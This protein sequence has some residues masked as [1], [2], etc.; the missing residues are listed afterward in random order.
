M[1]FRILLENIE[2]KREQRQRRKVSTSDIIQSIR[3]RG[4]IT[5]VIVEESSEGKYNLIAGERRYSASLELG[6]RDIPARTLGSLSSTERS[7]IELE[8]NIKRSDLEWPDFCQAIHKIHFL[9]IATD[10]NWNQ[11]KTADSVGLEE[12]TV[13]IVLRVANELLL[14]NSRLLEAPNY[15]AAYN[16][17]ARKDSRRLDDAFNELVGEEE[18]APGALG[19]NSTEQ[20]STS[21]TIVS[22]TTE[23]VINTDFLEY[24]RTY[25]GPPYT[26]LHCDFPYGIGLDKSAQGNTYQWGGYADTE[27]LYWRLCQTLA[28]NLD[29]LMAPY[30]H[31]MFWL[32]S[33]FTVIHKTLQFFSEKAPSLDFNPKPL[34]WMKTDGKG[35]LADP[36]RGPRHIYETALFASRG[37]RLIAAP[38]AD[39]YGA[40]KGDTG[41]QSEKPEP[42]LRHFFRMFLDEGSSFFDPTC[43]SGSSICAAESLGAK[44]CV[45]LEIN[46]EWAADANARV[47]KSRTLRAINP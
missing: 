35:I 9:Y 7:I 37:D 47:K 12:G 2:V 5:P 16:I 20:P 1:D 3:R 44:S 24:A 36:K 14:G 13:S 15:R 43:G 31:L 11:S 22:T 25:R 21:S 45:G 26:F 34:I 28:E 10:S 30:S 18:P 33:D 6:L 19:V 32:S 29:R 27:E 42:V 23:P 40:P 17:L 39:A 4:V 41:H 8:E 38:V 46:P